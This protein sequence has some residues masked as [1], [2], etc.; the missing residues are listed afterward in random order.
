MKL[1]EYLKRRRPEPE[2]REPEKPELPDIVTRHAVKVTASVRQAKERL[3]DLFE[4]NDIEPTADIIG[5][6]L[7]ICAENSGD[8][9]IKPAAATNGELDIPASLLNRMLDQRMG[10]RGGVLKDTSTGQTIVIA[11]APKTVQ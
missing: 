9:T 4:A 3:L 11:P 8:T 2:K 7:M 1:K 10:A 5:A 6:L